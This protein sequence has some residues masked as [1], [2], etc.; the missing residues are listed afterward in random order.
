MMMKRLALAA[1]SVVALA[2]QERA[3]AATPARVFT[4]NMVLQADRAI[5]VWGVGTPGEKVTVSFAG[6]TASATVDAKGDWQATLAAQRPCAEG[7]DLAVNDVTLRNVRVGDVYMVMGDRHVGWPFWTVGAQIKTDFDRYAD[8]NLCWYIAPLRRRASYP[9]KDLEP[10]VPKAG[11]WRS[12]ANKGELGSFPYFWAREKAEKSKMPVGVIVVTGGAYDRCDARMFMRPETYAATTNDA[13]NAQAY[14]AQN[15]TSEK[16]LAKLKAS[17]VEIKA[18]ADAAR[19]LPSGRYPGSNMAQLPNLERYGQVTTH[20]NYQMAPFLKTPLKGAVFYSGYG[21][22]YDP[23]EAPLA[24]ELK[25]DMRRIWGE[26]LEFT[27]V[28]VPAKTVM[29]G[30]CP[31]ECNRPREV[32]RALDPANK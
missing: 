13:R 4:D 23:K 17:A 11:H 7:R 5:P 2:A 24:Q 18:W 14:D 20:F 3:E 27:I 16:G 22:G 12:M 8:T 25:A 21:W 19:A 15:P 31:E 28:P 26:D 30:D 6:A 1:V 29:K 32:I 9:V 10:P